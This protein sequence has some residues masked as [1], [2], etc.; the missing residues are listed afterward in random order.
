MLPI[1]SEAVRGTMTRAALDVR[2]P[3]SG[4]VAAWGPMTIAVDIA[5]FAVSREPGASLVTYSLGSCV[6]VAIW[7]PVVCIGG[8][9]HYMLPDSSISAGNAQRNPAMFCDTGVAALFRA[10][11]ELGAIKDR[12]IVKVA[13]G[14]QLLEDG[15]GIEVGKRNYL[16][17][18]QIFWKNGVA[19]AAEDVGGSVS[20]TLRLDVGGGRVTVQTRGREEAL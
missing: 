17:L 16:A 1:V 18:R 10:A 11:Y 3:R 12:L 14:S 19:I 13:G 2:A 9:L 7:D 20:R 4:R 15:F 8:L 5:D 6:G